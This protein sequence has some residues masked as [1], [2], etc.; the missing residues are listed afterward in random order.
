MRLAPLERLEE[1]LLAVPALVDELL[2]E[3]P[4][5]AERIDGWL[6][7]VEQ[8]LAAQQLP[9]SATFA[10]LRARLASVGRGL[11]LPGLQLTRAPTARNWR[12]VGVCAIL[13]EATQTL[14][15]LVAPSR[16]AVADATNAVRQAVELG[17]IREQVGGTA[18]P[19]HAPE[20]LWGA[21]LTDP[22]LTVFVTRAASVVGDPDARTLLTRA[23]AGEPEPAGRAAQAG[24]RAQLEAGGR[25][26]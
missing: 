15:T 20:Q 16:A 3:G 10:T 24:E 14:A 23:A 21:L 19:W 12:Q 6:Q 17:R 4:L 13:D 7:E 11:R 2:A 9:A 5:A 8:Q 18:L 25:P 22:D 26:A 1:L